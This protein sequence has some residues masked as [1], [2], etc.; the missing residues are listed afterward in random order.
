M[1]K[2]YSINSAGRIVSERDIYS[3]GGFISKGSIGGKIASEEQLSQDGECWIAGGDISSRPDIRIK[4]NAF[5]GAFE[6]GSNPVHTDGVTEFSGNTKIPGR[7]SIRSFSADTKCDMIVRDSFIGIY[8]N[9]VCGPATNTKAFPFEQGRF[10]QDAPKGT[11]FTSATMRVDADNFVRN[12]AVLRIGKDT[13][14]YVPQGFNA[15]IYWAY[16]NDSPS[17]F[18]YAGESET[19][20]SALYKLSHPVYNTCMV[21]YARNPTLTPAELE[22][23][24]ARVIGHI[25]GSLLMDLRPESAS[26]IYVMD[27]SEFI[28]PTDNFGLNVTQLRFLA[29]GLINTTMYTKTDRQDYK[30]YGTFRNVEHLEYTKYLAYSFRSNQSSRIMIVLC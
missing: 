2:K 29:G 10:N 4:D 25:S 21:A 27:G 22:A 24:G 17:G 28:M 18:A 23:S 6:P 3:L 9:C 19:A 7:I 12:T 15:R 13:H 11:L 20:T 14:I 26:G 30:P 8:M 16:Y 5:I 1:G